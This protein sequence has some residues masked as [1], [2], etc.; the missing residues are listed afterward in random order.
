MEFYL[1]FP[2]G[3]SGAYRE[4]NFIVT[5]IM[6][7]NAELVLHLTVR[8]VTTRIWRVE[9]LTELISQIFIHVLRQV[10]SLFQSELS[11]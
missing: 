11:T 1:H 8:I 7:S 6:C 4:N 3:L 5:Y 2:L 10:Q 9:R